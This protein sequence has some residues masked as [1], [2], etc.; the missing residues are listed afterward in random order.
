LGAQVDSAH[1]DEHALLVEDDDDDDSFRTVED[2]RG[3]AGEIG[4]EVV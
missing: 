1:S 3:K 4:D 2:C